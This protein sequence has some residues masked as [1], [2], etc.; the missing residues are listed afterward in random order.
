MLHDPVSNY[1]DPQRLI[2]EQDVLF[3]QFPH[4][5]STQSHFFFSVLRTHF[6][7]EQTGAG[8]DIGSQP[9]PNCAV[10][11]SAAPDRPPTTTGVGLL[12]VGRIGASW[13]SNSLPEEVTLLP[14]IK[15]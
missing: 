8:L 3:R 13:T 6:Q 12:G 15:R 9:S 1:A 10:R 2:H 5:V 14:A 7:I 11:V 4:Q